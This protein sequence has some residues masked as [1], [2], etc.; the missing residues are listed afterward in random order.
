MKRL[1]IRLRENEWTIRIYWHSERGDAEE[2]VGEMLRL[3][4]PTEFAKDAWE[5]IASGKLNQGVTFSHFG[6]RQSVMVV[7]RGES[8]REEFNSLLHE[9]R[10]VNAHIG[11]ADGMAPYGE[12]VC[13]LQGKLAEGVWEI[14]KELVMESGEV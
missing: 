1:T 8:A 4:C 13:Y 11:E 9:M 3:G 2:I 14:V 7:G 5:N 10:H 6:R 12:E